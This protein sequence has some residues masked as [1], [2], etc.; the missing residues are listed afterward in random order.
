VNAAPWLR[1]DA[2]SRTL[3]LSVYVQ[4]NARTTGVTGLH[5]EDLKIRVAAPALDNKANAAVRELI[6][7]VLEVPASRVT[8][9]RGAAGRRKTLEIA[10]ARAELAERALALAAT[11]S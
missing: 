4:P 7:G 11:H 5:G 1:Y 3:T 10:D 8:I 9:R 6:A 2:K